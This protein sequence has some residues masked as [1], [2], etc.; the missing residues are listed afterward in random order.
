VHIAG[1]RNPHIFIF[2]RSV[3]GYRPTQDWVATASRQAQRRIGWA[4]R[5]IGRRV[6]RGL[7]T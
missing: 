1:H 2:R 4:Q 5:R 6:S 3:S 7:L